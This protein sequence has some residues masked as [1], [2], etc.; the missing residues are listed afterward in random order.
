MAKY[1]S[2]VMVTKLYVDERNIPHTGR[3]VSHTR[4]K[5]SLPTG[6]VILSMFRRNEVV[7]IRNEAVKSRAD[8]FIISKF[9]TAFSKCLEFNSTTITSRFPSIPRIPI[10]K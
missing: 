4:Q 9:V 2:I 3:F 8:W 5:I 6:V 10:H 7:I 1:R